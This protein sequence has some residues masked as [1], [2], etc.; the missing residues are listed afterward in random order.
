MPPWLPPCSTTDW[1]DGKVIYDLHFTDGLTSGT[2]VVDARTGEILKYSKMQE[3]RDR[4]VKVSVIG[5]AEAKAIAIAKD[6]LV[7]GNISKY[8]MNLKQKDESYV[9][10]LMFLCNG[11]RY[12]AEIA[13]AD[14]A[15][16]SFTRE[17]LAET[18][19]APAEGEGQTP[20]EG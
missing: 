8:E 19:R 14:G 2:Y 18:G 15:V 4:S 20:A 9:Y 11:V 16:V 1:V 10:E 6:G 5:E 13:A 17:V 12:T 3:P 7:D